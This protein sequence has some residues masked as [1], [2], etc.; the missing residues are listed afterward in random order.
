MIRA[1]GRRHQLSWL[2]LGLA[3]VALLSACGNGKTGSAS[4]DEASHLHAAPNG[5]LREET[6]TLS[7]MPGFLNGQSNEVLLAY[8]AAAAIGD[9][10][11]W[12]PCYCGC[13]ESAG[14]KSNLACFIHEVKPD[15]SV[16]WDDHGTRC[17]VCVHIVLKS[18]QMKA[19][20]K[21]DT[22]IRKQIDASY[23]SGYAAP[24]DTSLP[25]QA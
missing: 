17:G 22:D 23:Q 11:Q 9:T 8:R 13:G 15:G 20:G 3:L 24:T 10:L 18:A 1:A 16:V 7:S 5:D 25:P 21:S 2:L 14:H 6:E 19:E 12:I 4:P